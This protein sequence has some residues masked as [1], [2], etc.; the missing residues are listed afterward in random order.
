MSGA[1]LET[2]AHQ[3]SLVGYSVATERWA[4]ASIIISL[5][6]SLLNLGIGLASG[7]LA[8]ISEMVH[9]L[10][11]LLASVV[12]LIG[13]KISQRKNKSFPYG[14]YKVENVVA[15]V[16]SGLIFY[17]GYEIARE[18]LLS[19]Q[20]PTT[21]NIWILA[22]VVLSI[23]IP[24][25][26]G[27]FEFAAGK[28]ANSPSL[29]AS[30]MEY[31]THIFTSGVVLISMISDT[32]GLNIDRIASLIIVIFIL[33]TGWELLKDGM[34]VLLDA[35]LDANSLAQVRRIVES[36]PATVQVKSLTGRN[37]GRYRFLEV[38]MSLR[39]NDLKSA[40][41]VSRRIE[42][43]IK[44]EVPNVERVLIHYEPIQPANCLYA[45]PLANLAGDMS[46]HFGGAPYFALIN[47]CISDLQVEKQEIILNPFTQL[48][49]AKGIRV[50]EWLISLKVDRVVL[51]ENLQGK[52]PEY[53]FKDAGVELIYTAANSWNAALEELGKRKSFSSTKGME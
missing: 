36:D 30:A 8:V 11:D 33:K 34:R 9:N 52:G 24:L 10:V 5:A 26:F 16:L 28:S 46:E 15:V 14:L 17:T 3:E 48:P 41:E 25:I 45:F 4:W 27:H 23:A 47:Q 2:T 42:K 51:K 19:V 7:S 40:H 43:S 13:L 49:K 1:I 32:F 35:S 18:A 44:E 20:K 37:S 50:A 38:E 39:T 22:G 31:R 6:L 21:V 12:V 29:I 53:V